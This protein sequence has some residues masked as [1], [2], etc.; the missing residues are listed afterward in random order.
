MEEIVIDNET[1]VNVIR[2]VDALNEQAWKVHITQPKL[3]L[4]LSSEAK[5]IAEEYSYQK[6]VA[7]SIRNMGVSHRYLCESPVRRMQRRCSNRGLT[8]PRV[9]SMLG[10][11]GE[12][13]HQ[14][15]GC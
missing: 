12:R 8:G 10:D 6:G 9:R 13:N 1:G 3:A 7:Y 2:K 15:K 5:K 14:T 11:L 4:E